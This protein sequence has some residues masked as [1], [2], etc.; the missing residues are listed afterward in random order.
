MKRVEGVG[1]GHDQSI[2]N[3]TSKKLFY[4]VEKTSEQ[5]TEL[6]MYILFRQEED[7]MIIINLKIDP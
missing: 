7:L 1:E 3:K 5:S 4:H 6:F 2:G